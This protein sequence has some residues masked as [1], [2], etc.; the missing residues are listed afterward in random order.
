MEAFERV[1]LPGEQLLWEG[2]PYTGLM[3][4][5]IDIFLVPFSLVWAGFPASM[6]FQDGL[7][8]VPGPAVMISGLF[9]VIGVYATVGRFLL[10]IAIR[11]TLRYAVTNKRV[12]IL[13]G[14]SGLRSVT[15]NALP[16]LD[17]HERSD[18]SGTLRFGSGGGLLQGGNFAVWQPTFDS[19]PQFLRIPNARAV[20]ELIDRVG[21]GEAAAG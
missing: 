19:V 1:R 6:L 16:M 20:Y 10:D 8:E 5:P 2:R 7:A 14:K 11:R 18:G 3:F 17:L 15:I 13:R 12:L 21:R 9:L 4:R